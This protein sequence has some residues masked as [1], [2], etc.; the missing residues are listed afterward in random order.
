MEA[1]A[2]YD[3]ESI[4][5]QLNESKYS[6]FF[7]SAWF[8]Q[9]ITHGDGRV[10]FNRR[11]PRCSDVNNVPHVKAEIGKVAMAFNNSEESESAGRGG[12]EG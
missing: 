1:N 8:I 11:A 12:R 7:H 9:A 3:L 10:I 6:V 4:Q 5:V 2:G